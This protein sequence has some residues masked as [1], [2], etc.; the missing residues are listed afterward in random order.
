MSK[1]PHNQRIK[2]HRVIYTGGVLSHKKGSNRNIFVLP[3]TH[4][5]W[6]PRLSYFNKLPTEK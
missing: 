6:L 3:S 5:L 1:I 2:F 4:P